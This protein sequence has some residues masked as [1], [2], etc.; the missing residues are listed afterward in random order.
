MFPNKNGILRSEVENFSRVNNMESSNLNVI[1]SA[2]FV[3]SL[4]TRKCQS[5]A[6]L[7]SILRLKDKTVT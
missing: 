5:S 4:L 1:V 2:S 3:L 7:N 6:R